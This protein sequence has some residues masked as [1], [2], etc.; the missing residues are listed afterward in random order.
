MNTEGTERSKTRT[1]RKRDESGLR[2]VAEME[3]TSI[4]QR[5]GAEDGLAA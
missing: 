2:D 3:M 5:Q 1:Q 4:L